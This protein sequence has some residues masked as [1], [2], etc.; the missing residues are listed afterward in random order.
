M[1]NHRLFEIIKTNPE[2]Q[3]FQNEKSTFTLHRVGPLLWNQPSNRHSECP[4]DID[5]PNGCTGCENSVCECSVSSLST[6][7]ESVL[8]VVFQDVTENANWNQCLDVNGA[9]LAR[10]IY[11]CNDNGGCE[12]ECVSQFKGRTADCPCEVSRIIF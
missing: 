10:C 1:R 8:T 3:K 4:C 11:N 12:D 9:S 7:S 2:I 5:C 6:I